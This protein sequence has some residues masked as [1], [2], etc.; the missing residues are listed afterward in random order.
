DRGRR[1]GG[2]TQR[3]RSPALRRARGDGQRPAPRGRKSPAAVATA[4][5]TVPTTRAGTS[6][7]AKAVGVSAP[8]A[9]RNTAV[10]RATPSAT[11]ISRR[12]ALTLLAVAWSASATPAS[13]AVATG[14]NVRPMPTPART[15]A[16]TSVP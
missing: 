2:G 14:A 12:V 1:A 10:S 13:T 16:G 5:T 11:P 9:A 7:V 8:P 6:P 15:N 3:V 4:S